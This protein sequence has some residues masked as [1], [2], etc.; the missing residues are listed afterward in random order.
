LTA[1]DWHECASPPSCEGEASPIDTC[2]AQPCRNRVSIVIEPEFVFASQT[3]LD[4]PADGLLIANQRLRWLFLLGQ[5]SG[6]EARS[7]IARPTRSQTACPQTVICVVELPASRSASRIAH[8]QCK[9]AVPWFVPCPKAFPGGRTRVEAMSGGARDWSPLCPRIGKHMILTPPSH[10]AFGPACVVAVRYL[11]TIARIGSN[12]FEWHKPRLWRVPIMP[13][14]LGL[15]QAL[16]R[17][18]HILWLPDDWILGP[19]LIPSEDTTRRAN[20]RMAMNPKLGK[21]RRPIGSSYLAANRCIAAPR[22]HTCPLP[23]LR[24]QSRLD[25]DPHRHLHMS[26]NIVPGQYRARQSASQPCD[27]GSPVCRHDQ[28]SP[29]ASA[30][31]NRLALLTPRATLQKQAC[32]PRNPFLP[33]QRTYP[34]LTH[35]PRDGSPQR[36]RLLNRRCPRPRSR[37]MVHMH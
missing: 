32:V 11:R 2:D 8:N 24:S 10:I 17:P 14:Q 30:R 16:C 12:P 5:P 4:R 15:S 29:A 20:E 9:P 37:I 26:D 28:E 25:E 1:A 27:Q 31:I 33:E 21:R 3:V 13:S 6:E 36:Q 22:P 7:S 23:C 35:F 18:M 19:F 34:L